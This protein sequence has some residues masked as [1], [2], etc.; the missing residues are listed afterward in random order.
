MLKL[1]KMK[2]T[3]SFQINNTDVKVAA[4]LSTFE[5]QAIITG[6]LNESID[7]KLLRPSRIIFDSV[8]HALIVLKYTDIEIEDMAT[9]K[10]EDLY[11]IFESNGVI[12]MTLKAIEE[13]NRGEI[14]ELTQYADIAYDELNTQLNSAGAA[15]NSIISGIVES[16]AV[17][18]SIEATANKIK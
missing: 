7:N 6:A 17:A 12:E 10:I 3:G 18:A 2:K 4:N 8:L 1:G 15:V 16:S 14:G 13:I 9:L 11:D 5:K